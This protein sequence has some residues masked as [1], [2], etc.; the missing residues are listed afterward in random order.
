MNEI[1]KY[2]AL[3]LPWEQVS[4][5]VGSMVSAILER[6]VTCSS[7]GEDDNYWS[8][9]AENDCFTNVEIVRLVKAVDGNENMLRHALPIDSN[10]SISLD[11]LLCRAI[12]QRALDIAWDTEFVAKDALC[13]QSVRTL[14]YNR[15]SI[16]FSAGAVKGNVAK[17]R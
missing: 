10:T 5:Y 3:K 4:R 16:I 6:N 2:S 15:I 12:L 11:M 13:L 9:A 1:Q 8:V 17:W 7:K 14:P